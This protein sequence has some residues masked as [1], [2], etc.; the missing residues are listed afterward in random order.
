[1]TCLDSC[2]VAPGIYAQKTK[3]E[4]SRKWNMRSV[5]TQRELLCDRHQGEFNVFYVGGCVKCWQES[6]CESAPVDSVVNF[7]AWTTID[8]W[9]RE[10]PQ[11]TVAE[12]LAELVRRIKV[13]AVTAP[14]APKG[15]EAARDDD[16]NYFDPISLMEKAMRTSMLIECDCPRESGACDGECL[17]AKIWKL[18][19]RARKLVTNAAATTD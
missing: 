13:E 11:A 12:C 3:E 14:P 4:A 6:E 2:S 10:N 9:L 5:K 18:I 7:E 17:G 1:M 15:E 16:V 8:Q 19:H